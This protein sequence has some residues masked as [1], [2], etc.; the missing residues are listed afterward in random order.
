MTRAVFSMVSEMV[1]MP[2]MV[3][4]H[5]LVAGARVLAGPLR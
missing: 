2:W 4:G 5:R 1:F 3:R